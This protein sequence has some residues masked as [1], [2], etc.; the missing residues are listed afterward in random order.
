M[1]LALTRRGDYPEPIARELE[2]LVS[3]ITTADQV[4]HDAEGRQRVT[5]AKWTLA[6]DQSVAHNTLTRVGV[7]LPGSDNAPGRLTFLPGGIIRIGETGA[8]QVLGQIRYAT[9]ATGGR[10]VQLLRNQNEIAFTFQ[11]SLGVAW[12]QATETIPCVPGD[13]LELY[14]YQTSGGALNVESASGQTFLRIVRVA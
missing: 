4:E 7:A 6:A 8:Y 1:K 11:P 5:C 12:V 2:Q 9:N 14:A 13:T 3:A 10:S